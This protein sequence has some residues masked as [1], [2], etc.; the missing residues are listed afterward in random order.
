MTW[1]APVLLFFWFYIWRMPPRTRTEPYIYVFN[2]LPFAV[3]SWLVG[4]LPSMVYRCRSVSSTVLFY[5]VVY[6]VLSV[7]CISTLEPHWFFFFRI[8]HY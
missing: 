4:Y 3:S 2:A 7:V 5:I 6:P 8:R 1:R